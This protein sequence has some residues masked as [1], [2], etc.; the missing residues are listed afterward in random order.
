MTLE[1][2]YDPP[3]EETK[4]RISG[5]SPSVWAWLVVIVG[6]L[7]AG[8]FMFF[9]SCFGVLFL[10]GIGNTS[11]NSGFLSSAVPYLFISIP[12]FVFAITVFLL[13]R[14]GR[15][16]INRPRDRKFADD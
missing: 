11:G 4:P 3:A 16:T 13:I 15:K 9:V 2:P 1:N 10:F 14:L 5:R 8:G 12:F 7:V 6:S